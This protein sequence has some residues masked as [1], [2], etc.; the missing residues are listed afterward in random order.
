MAATL[1]QSTLLILEPGIHL[2]LISVKRSV[3]IYFPDGGRRA[4]E[5]PLLTI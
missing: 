4:A 5:E 1:P 3:A 2:K